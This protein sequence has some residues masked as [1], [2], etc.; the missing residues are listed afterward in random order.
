M[1]VFRSARFGV[2]KKFSEIELH[3]LS[4]NHHFRRP[5]PDLHDW[6]FVNCA[7]NA[8]ASFGTT[9]KSLGNCKENI[10]ASLGNYMDIGQQLSATWY[11]FETNLRQC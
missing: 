4:A 10:W 9:L 5:C 7:D 1:I 11:N 2:V 8:Q 3:V 6:E